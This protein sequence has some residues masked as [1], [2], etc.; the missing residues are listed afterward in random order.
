[1]L[2][3]E[4]QKKLNSSIENIQM[5]LMGLELVVPVYEYD[6]AITQALAVAKANKHKRDL[7]RKI[8]KEQRLASKK[9][10]RRTKRKAQ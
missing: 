3:P 8:A 9:H 2:Q 1:M 5:E 10:N 6:P 7:E 4:D